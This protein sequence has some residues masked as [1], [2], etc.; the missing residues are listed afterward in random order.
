MQSIK[1]AKQLHELVKDEPNGTYAVLVN[2]YLEVLAI[3][4]L[5]D[6]YA[7]EHIVAGSKIPSIAAFFLIKLGS[8]TIDKKDLELAKHYY[9]HCTSPYLI[10]Y[11][12]ADKKNFTSF[13]EI[14][15]I[16]YK[17]KAK[18]LA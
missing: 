6:N 12:V 11:L 4:Q 18:I 17:I 16:N 7:F 14:N 1:N 15:Y 3:N 9:L 8:N 5:R 10:D 13:K 2:D